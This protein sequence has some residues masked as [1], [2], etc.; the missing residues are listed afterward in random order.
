M[1]N[2][3]KNFPDPFAGFDESVPESSRQLEL[4]FC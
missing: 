2:A 3:V 4:Q 1:R